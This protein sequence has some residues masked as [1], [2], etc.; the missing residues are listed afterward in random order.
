MKKNTCLRIGK[1]YVVDDMVDC[2]RVASSTTTAAA[3]TTTNDDDIGTTTYI[4][5]CMDRL[6]CR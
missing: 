1:S 3:A 5:R 4:A 2:S 6:Q